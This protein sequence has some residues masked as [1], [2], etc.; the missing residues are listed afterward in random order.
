[1]RLIHGLHF[2]NLHGDIYGGLVAAV[3][4][5]PLALAFGVASGA[6]AIAGLYG[7]IIVGLFAALFG[8]T[9]AQISGPTGPMTVVM[10]GMLLQFAHEPRLAFTAVILGGYLQIVIGLLGW[11][12]YIRLTPYPVISG[13][14]SGIGCII[15]ILQLAPL[16]GHA[17]RPEGVVAT[18]KAL[19]RL[20]ADP[21]WQA[22]TA[23][24]LS[25][26]VVYLTPV[27]I[28]RIIPGTLLALLVVTPVAASFLPD[29]PTIG[30]VPK[31]LPTLVTPL[32]EWGTL[33]PVLE[34]AVV[35]CLLGNIDSLL[36]SLVHDN[37]TRT[38]HDSN[39]ECV[40]QGI[41]NMISGLFGGLPGAGATMRTVANV[42]TGGR[43]PLSGAL[44]AV[45]LLA[46][47][48]ELGPLA[49]Q[50]PLPALA[51]ILLKVGVDI[52]DWRFMTHVLRA[53]RTEVLIMILVLLLTALVDLITA[54]AVG[55]VVAS[56]L[57]VKRMADLELANFRIITAP[58]EE[59]LLSPEEAK[60]L[61]QNQGRIVFIHVDSPM[62]FGSANNMVRRLDRVKEF[63][64]FQSVVLDLSNV[65][66][67]D[68]T[69]AMAVEDMLR[70]IQDHRQHLFF[71][72]MQPHVKEVLEGMGVFKLI[73]P[74]HIYAKRLEALRAAAQMN[75]QPEQ[76]ALPA[77]LGA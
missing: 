54:V 40:G 13:F 22:A 4:A 47:L 37:L 45:V 20:Y 55:V 65:P 61:A 10:A 29:A 63:S 11:G 52:I 5:L 8:G 31:G 23:G 49:S 21:N 57:F 62:S 15:I 7:A 59:A 70:V 44:H 3:V 27:R 12:K 64:T 36:T 74:G 48:L 26:A 1:M 39:R 6:G 66:L 25:L 71:V 53:P 75:K 19:P 50:I 73:R 51:G 76:K 33:R 58:H 14:M 28:T 68:G 34:A 43:T 42:R 2:K 60:I 77:G 38:H 9:P 24:L 32:I 30:D 46:I 17:A 72:G 35:L 56:L 18:L 16:I 41:G 67:I 69:A